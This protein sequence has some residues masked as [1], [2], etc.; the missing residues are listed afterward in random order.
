MVRTSGYSRF[1]GH[2]VVKDGAVGNITGIYAIYSKKSKYQGG[3]SDYA[4]YQI[5]LNR[6]MDL[7]FAESDFLTE[8][9]VIAL[10]P[11]DSYVTPDVDDD[12][13]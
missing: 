2:G 12:I 11:A 9:E 6:Y 3:A 8:E 4:T 1:S 5:S 10:T 7:E 13:D